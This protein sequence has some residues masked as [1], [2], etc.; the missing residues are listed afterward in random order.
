L[1]D[2]TIAGRGY[3][4][5]LF[6]KQGCQLAGAMKKSEENE[7]QTEKFK[8]FSI[9]HEALFWTLTEKSTRLS[10]CQEAKNKRQE[11]EEFKTNVLKKFIFSNLL[12]ITSR[13]CQR[14]NLM[15]VN[16]WRTWRDT[17]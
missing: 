6:L 11:I 7:P 3:R 1:T 15:N 10:I 2:L 17:V 16:S 8:R 9:L 5:G 4:E 12:D 13:S 14:L